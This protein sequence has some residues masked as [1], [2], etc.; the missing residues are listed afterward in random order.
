MKTK[1][2]YSAELR[3]CVWSHVHPSVC[4]IV[5]CPPTS[6]LTYASVS[7]CCITLQFPWLLVVLQMWLKEVKIGFSISCI[8]SERLC[9]V[10]VFHPQ[11]HIFWR[12][13]VVAV[14]LLK[15]KVFL[16]MMLCRFEGNMI[17]EMW[18]TCHQVTWCCIPEDLNLHTLCDTL[19]F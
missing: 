19:S 15:I 1:L 16:V 7:V 6:M 3:K 2:T 18:R 10:S 12:F 9:S 11:G 8:L 13:E 14:E 5:T 4:P 17:I